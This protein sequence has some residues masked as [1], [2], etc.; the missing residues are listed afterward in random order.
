MPEEVR[1]SE[2]KLW[3]RCRIWELNHLETNES[4]RSVIERSVLTHI[5]NEGIDCPLYNVTFSNVLSDRERLS[6]VKRHRPIHR[7][8]WSYQNLLRR[9]DPSR[10]RWRLDYL[11]VVFHSRKIF[12]L[13]IWQRTINSIT[14]P[15]IDRNKRNFSHSEWRL[16]RFRKTARKPSEREDFIRLTN[17]ALRKCQNRITTE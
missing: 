16:W 4:Y 5:T 8:G 13:A 14:S 12:N 1:Y 17:N 11:L 10:F 7:F 9:F 3:L 15:S 2:S 6:C